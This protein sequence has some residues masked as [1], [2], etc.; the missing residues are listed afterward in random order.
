[1]KNQQVQEL[2]ENPRSLHFLKHHYSTASLKS[3]Y[4]NLRY[5]LLHMLLVVPTLCNLSDSH[6]LLKQILLNLIIVVHYF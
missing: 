5:L 6:V 2:Q 3:S 1:M 4:Y